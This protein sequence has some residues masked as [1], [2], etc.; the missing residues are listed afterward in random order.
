[1]EESEI[2]Y[3]AAMSDCAFATTCWEKDWRLLLLDPDY[4]R[5]KMIGNHKFPFNDRLLVINNVKNIEEVKKAADKK[6]AEG[7]LTRYLVASEKE[8]EI[9]SFF[10]LKRSDFRMGLD[11]KDYAGVNPEWIY[12]NA[13][14]PLC[15]IY[16]GTSNYLLYHTGDVYLDRPVSWIARS[17]DMMEKRNEIQV[18]NLLWDNMRGEA[19]RESYRKSWNFYYAKEGFSDQQFLV[20]RD[21]FRKPIY[22]EIRED[23]LHY[24]RGDVFEKRVFSFLKNRKFE[25][26]IFR[27]GSY[28]HKNIM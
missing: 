21:F 17:I 15:A 9:L 4:L 16:E 19:K 24:P 5:I 28:T 11:A 3:H 18:A 10:L 20:K 13:L 6:I 25:R 22:G 8:E 2:V 7:V 26:I 1:M 23:S 12:Y 27:R 14:G